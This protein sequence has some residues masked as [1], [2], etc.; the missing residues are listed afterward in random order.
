MD[1]R[2][3]QIIDQKIFKLSLYQKYLVSI[4]RLSFRK[5]DIVLIDNIFEELNE[6]ENIELL[7]LIKKYFIN[8]NT[9]VLFATS[10]QLIAKTIASKIYYLEFGAIVKEENLEE[11][12]EA[13]LLKDV[14][15]QEEVKPPKTKVKSIKTKSDNTKPKKTTLKKVVTKKT[16]NIKDQ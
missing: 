13:R 4:A 2:L 10:N 11:T 7:T 5:L 9:L 8:S 1:F 3:E 14:S 15:L 6:Q 16:K 12:F